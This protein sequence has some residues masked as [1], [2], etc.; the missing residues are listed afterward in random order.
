MSF[1]NCKLIQRKSKL[2]NF[3]SLQLVFIKWLKKLNISN[4]DFTKKNKQQQPC[5][6]NYNF[7]FPFFMCLIFLSDL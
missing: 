5:L 3:L 1:C 2:E 6:K 4:L 7:L